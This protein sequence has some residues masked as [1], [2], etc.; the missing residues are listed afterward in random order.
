MPLIPG[1]RDRGRGLSK[2]EARWSTEKVLGNSGIHRE[3]LS[4][5]PY[6]YPKKKI[7][8]EKYAKSNLC[9]HI[10]TEA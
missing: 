4:P 1:L 2:F 9:C 7:K 5:K 8:R 6:I 3:T 10:L